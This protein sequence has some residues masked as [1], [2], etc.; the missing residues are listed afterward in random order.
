MLCALALV[1]VGVGIALTQTQ[2][3]LFGSTGH[4][5]HQ[6]VDPNATVPSNDPGRLTS[7]GSVR[8]RYW[9]EALK[10]FKDN[11]VLGVGAGGYATVRARYRNDLLEVRHAHGYVV[12]TLADLGILGLGLSL[13]ALVAWWVTAARATGLRR[14]DRGRPYT[15]ERIG[16]LT[17]VAVVVVF[18]VHSFVDW[19]WFVPGNA[20]PAIIA[21][22]WI[23]GRGPLRRNAAALA[24]PPL[25]LARERW[26]LAAGAAAVLVSLIVAWAAWQPLGSLN[27]SNDALAALER[28]DVNAARS[29]ANNAHNRDPLALDPLTVLAIVETRS[30]NREA[31]QRDLENEVQ[32]Q[33]ANHETWLRLADFQLNQL[34]RPKEALR[35]LSAALYLDPRDPM[36]ISA[37]LQVAAQVSGKPV[38]GAAAV[39]PAAGSTGPPAPAQPPESG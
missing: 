4:A 26:R 10:I 13:L 15:P 30:G 11:P 32:M 7:A 34:K 12:Q 19:T 6:L 8:A 27:S 31:A 24:R 35:S 28:G 39:A 1:P 36:T 5:V 17:L 20:L 25:R 2:R 16:L 29:L 9:N 23:A 22:G 18:G 37:Y 38:A 33:P 21:A 14:A 3:G